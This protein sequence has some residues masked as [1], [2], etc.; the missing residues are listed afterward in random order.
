MSNSHL[1]ERL[2]GDETASQSL[3]PP[4]SYRMDL[5][6]RDI[7]FSLHRGVLDKVKC[8]PREKILQ[9]VTGTISSGKLTAIMGP[10]G[11]GKTTVLSVIS[12]K[13][14]GVVGGKLL[15]NGKEDK[16]S[17]YKE[18]VGF[19]PQEDVMQR[20][21]TVYENLM[22]NANWRLPRDQTRR[23]KKQMVFMVMETLGLTH[24]AHKTI[25]DET[26]RGIS[27]GQ[28]KRVNIG[29][30]LVANPSLLFL[31]EPTSGLDSTTAMEVVGAL[32]EVARL[33]VNV[34]AVLHQPRFEL[35]ALFDDLL[36]LA[37]GGKTAF[38]GTIYC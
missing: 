14:L 16:T 37:P 27:G 18:I 2:L 33:G 23:E 8:K 1:S 21:L 36:L 10:S 22:F 31:D 7:N 12:G 29:M 32:K 6:L 13:A 38:L 35:F 9:K 30:E 20:S 5:K 17:R 15:I 19:V 28:R 25:G 11:A 4:P 34:V 24:L 3:L 26:K